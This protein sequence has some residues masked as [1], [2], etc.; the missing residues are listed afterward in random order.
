MG[1]ITTHISYH[2]STDVHIIMIDSGFRVMLPANMAAF[3]FV[4]GEEYVFYSLLWTLL[5]FKNMSDDEII[6]QR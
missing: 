6:C 5:S 4:S 2:M 3:V 1:T